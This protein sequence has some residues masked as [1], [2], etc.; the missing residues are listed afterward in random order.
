MLN[1][2]AVVSKVY[3]LPAVLI[4]RSLKVASPPDAETV[5]DPD[6]VPLPGLL[7]M[8][9]VMES[10]AVVTRLPPAS[11]TRTLIAGEMV[12]AAVVLVGSTL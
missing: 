9:R 4:E 3:A 12:N 6:K 8:A 10:V 5:K 11:W 1:P 7:L 2:E